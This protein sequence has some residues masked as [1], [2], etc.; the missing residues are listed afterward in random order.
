[1][2]LSTGGRALDRRGRALTAA[3]ALMWAAV[4]VGYTVS[5]AVRWTR[6]G[7]APGLGSATAL[8]AIA[9]IWLSLLLRNCQE[10]GRTPSA[11]L[12][13]LSLLL[14]ALLTCTMTAD[15]VLVLRALDSR[16]TL[17]VL[18]AASTFAFGY[19]MREVLRDLSA[20][21]EGGARRRSDGA[22][23]HTAASKGRK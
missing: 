10:R 22:Q 14:L 9:A 7:Q 12:T 23:R 21:G 16:G 3:I 18:P 19:V 2:G 17:P 4:T 15:V 20:T 6:R 5:L 11:V 8:G 13:R 1:M